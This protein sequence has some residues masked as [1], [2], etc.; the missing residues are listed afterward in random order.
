M[1]LL[2]R[3][4]ALDESNYLAFYLYSVVLNEIGMLDKA[5]ELLAR[6]N[7]LLPPGEALGSLEIFGGQP[8]DKK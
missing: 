3:A 7:E 2:E 4:A 5:E 1:S 8:A 6:C